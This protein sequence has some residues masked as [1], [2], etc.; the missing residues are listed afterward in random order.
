[1]N[2]YLFLDNT[3][4]HHQFTIDDLNK[5]YCENIYFEYYSN[6]T[7]YIFFPNN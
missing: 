1:M 2:I 6:I 4:T 5:K 3:F 7:R